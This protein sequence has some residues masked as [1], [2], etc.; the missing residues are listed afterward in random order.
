M[1]LLLTILLS[2][3]CDLIS[4][5]PNVWYN[6]YMIFCIAS[7][8][9]LK[10]LNRLKWNQICL[11]HQMF[12]ITS[13]WYLISDR[14]K[15]ML[16]YAPL[17]RHWRLSRRRDEEKRRNLILRFDWRPN[18]IVWGKYLSSCWWCVF[19]PLVS[20]PPNICLSFNNG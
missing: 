5:P 16:G 19:L 12:D 11:I 20:F 8:W 6:L 3:I 9:Y 15:L 18:K 2:A 17:G 10:D 7:I 4:P 1:I 14:S 13:I